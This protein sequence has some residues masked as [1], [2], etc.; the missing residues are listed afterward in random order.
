[1]QDSGNKQKGFSTFDILALAFGAMIGWG[2]V[3]LSGTWIS[4]AGV[5]GSVGAFVTGGVL[6]IFIGMIYAELT[7][8]MP[9]DGGTIRFAEAAFNDNGGRIISWILFLAY[10]SVIAFESI[11]FASVLGHLFGEGIRFGLLYHMGATPVYL[12]DIIIAA[13]GTM[14]IIGINYAG[15]TWIARFQN[16]VTIIILLSGLAIFFGNSQT[17][18]NIPQITE[19]KNGFNGFMGVLI[20]TPFMFM[21]FDVIPQAAGE[22]NVPAKKLGKLIIIAVLM[23]AFWY[24]GIIFSVGNMVND[25]SQLTEGIAAANAFSVA[26]GGALWAKYVVI[27][28]GIGGIVTSWNAFFVGGS[29]IMSRM[30]E[31]GWVPFHKHGSHKDINHASIIFLGMISMLSP[32]LGKEFLTK[33]VNAGSYAMILVYG[34]VVA[35]F[36]VLRKNQPDMPRPYKV[37]HPRLAT[38]ITIMMILGTM[39]ACMPGFST[40]LKASEW[41]ILFIWGAIAYTLTLFS[42]HQSKTTATRSRAIPE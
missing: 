19:A 1:M 28:A 20:M 14:L 39:I 10:V 38:T 35:S 40:S 6:I 33:F 32:F 24:I 25:K 34:I 11:A 31:S 8:M 7:T 13:I 16:L 15:N 29:Q 18:I 12:S 26:M 2:W 3:V 22:M 41:A 27:V 30:I 17:G 42:K 23:A 9:E 21:G 5:L 4:E 37:K 36:I